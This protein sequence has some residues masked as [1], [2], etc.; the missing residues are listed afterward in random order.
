[1]EFPEKQSQ[2]KLSYSSFKC[3]L[4]IFNVSLENFF[5]KI[6]P[7]ILKAP[8]NYLCTL[9]FCFN[10]CNFSTR[11]YTTVFTLMSEFL[12]DFSFLALNFIIFIIACYSRVY[13][14]HLYKHSCREYK[15][16]PSMLLSSSL[17]FIKDFY[18]CVKRKNFSSFRR[19]NKYFISPKR[20]CWFIIERL[21]LTFFLI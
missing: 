15:E 21:S 19:S 18:L 2:H 9:F 5:V 13:S 4:I 11:F 1:M 17:I 3:T 20:K 12:E 8:Q 16:L 6:F 14:L 10:D 7:L